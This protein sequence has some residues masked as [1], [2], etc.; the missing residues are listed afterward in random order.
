MSKRQK[1]EIRTA[2]LLAVVVGRHM[3]KLLQP[4]VKLRRELAR[5]ANLDDTTYA[6][7]A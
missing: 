2:L 7:A 6:L 3:E 4:Q 1:Q 5:P